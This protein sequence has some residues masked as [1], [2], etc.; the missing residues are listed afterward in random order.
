[1]EKHLTDAHHLSSIHSAHHWGRSKHSLWFDNWLPI[2]PLQQ[3]FGDGLIYD[4]G[5]P[6]DARVATVIW[7]G[8]WHW[9]PANSPDLIVK[10][11]I[12]SDM[13][14]NMTRQDGVKWRLT[15]HGDFTLH[16]AWNAIRTHRPVVPWHSLIWY[17]NH[18]KSLCNSMAC[19]SAEAKHTR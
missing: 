12:P 7:D 5:L 11:S 17:P 6:R 14:P 3:Y 13:H 1:M 9:P 8:E 19:S 15:S 4:S 10:W 2:G 18:T 16:S